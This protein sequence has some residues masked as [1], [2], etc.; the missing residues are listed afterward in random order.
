MK[1]WK[2]TQNIY[3]WWVF[4]CTLRW[5]SCKNTYFLQLTWNM[6]FVYE[7][8]YG[9]YVKSVVNTN[10]FNWNLFTNLQFELILPLGYWQ[11]SN[12]N[13]YK[14][15]SD[16]WRWKSMWILF[17]VF[18]VCLFFSWWGGGG[19]GLIIV[20]K[21]GNFVYYLKK[22]L[23][24]RHCNTLHCFII[25]I[26]VQWVLVQLLNF[27]L[28]L[29]KRRWQKWKALAAQVISVTNFQPAYTRNLFPLTRL[30]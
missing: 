15:L 25:V 16:V 11:R 13:R 5:N 28:S 9:L 26:F 14:A 23:S 10:I 21:K 7:P 22:L 30:L 2:Y 27:R 24:T 6:I 29:R 17:F 4:L 3:V 19:D 20:R 18:S 8:H 12:A 1:K